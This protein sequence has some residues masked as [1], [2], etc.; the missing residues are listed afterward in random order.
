M[1]KPLR[2]AINDV[3]VEY[4]TSKLKGARPKLSTRAPRGIFCCK[5]VSAR[6]QRLAIGGGVLCPAPF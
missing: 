6:M 4:V 3:V 1:Q 2:E 5:P